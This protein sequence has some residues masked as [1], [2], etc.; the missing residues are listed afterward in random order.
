MQNY[1]VFFSWYDIDQYHWCLIQ[2]QGSVDENSR[3]DDEY[4]DL[5]MEDS[6]DDSYLPDNEVDEPTDMKNIASDK[7]APDGMVAVD[8][9]QCNLEHFLGEQLTGGGSSSGEGI[10]VRRR[11]LSDPFQLPNRAQSIPLKIL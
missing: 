5:A 7:M 3:S 4:D 2:F 10:K 6:L 1:N 9:Y 11:S 8:K